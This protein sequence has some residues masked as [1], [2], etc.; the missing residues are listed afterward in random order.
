MN[1]SMNRSVQDLSHLRAASHRVS[2]YLSELIFILVLQ[3]TLVVVIGM[4][5]ETNRSIL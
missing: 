5:L 2:M 1:V 3:I 4:Y